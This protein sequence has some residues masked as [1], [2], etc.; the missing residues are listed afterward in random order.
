MKRLGLLLL[1]CLLAFPVWKWGLAQ[2]I[3][4]TPVRLTLVTGDKGTEGNLRFSLYG[5]FS[6]EPF[7]VILNAR[8]DLQPGRTD[9]YEYNIPYD[10]C[11][12]FAWSLEL[13]PG[14]TD[15]WVGAEFYLSIDGEEVYLN[16]DFASG[17]A[18]STTMTRSGTWDATTAYRAR[19]PVRPVVMTF[20]TIGMGTSSALDFALTGDFS[21]SPYALRLLREE[22]YGPTATGT[23]TFIVPLPFC[24]ITGWQLNERVAAPTMPGMLGVLLIEIDGMAVWFDEVRYTP[25]E[26][27]SML[28]AAGDWRDRPNYREACGL[29]ASPTPFVMPD[30]VITPPPV[31]PDTGIAIPMPIFTLPAA[32]PTA[33][34]ESVSPLGTAVI[35]PGFL[36][37]R[38]T[39]G[40]QGRARPGDPN[41]MRTGPSTQN[42]IVGFIPGGAPFQVI[43]GPVCDPAGIAWWQ[44]D[45]NGLIAWTAEGQRDRY[46]VDPINP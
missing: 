33:P 7:A 1:L 36:P 17:S 40:G 25:V 46:F 18:I 30:P 44:V 32:T 16:R 35:C 9:T 8:D 42:P 29:V 19:C 10:F 27:A 2:P 39:P 11:E 38:L 37:S 23:Y 45:Y 21:A 4:S 43:N 6:G 14:T 24:S 12:V 15:E 34:V 22:I 26:G 3:P 13:A 5:S 31:I 28:M 41:R 20:V